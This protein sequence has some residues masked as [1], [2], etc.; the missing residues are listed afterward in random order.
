M[1]TPVRTGTHV[2]G[3]HWVAEYSETAHEIRV[4]RK[5]FDVGVY[6]APPTLFGD[7]AESGS[8]SCADHRAVQAAIHAFLT[9]FIAEHDV[10]E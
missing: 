2:E 4:L 5:G 6:R 9:R 8:K 10:E 1:K 3:I 7:E